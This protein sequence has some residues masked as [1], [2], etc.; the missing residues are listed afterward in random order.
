VL[1]ELFC[2]AIT[3]W[4]RKAGFIP[5]R[6]IAPKDIVSGAYTRLGIER[7]RWDKKLLAA[8]VEKRQ[9]RRTLGAEDFGEQAITRIVKML[10]IFSA[11]KPDY[12][13]WLSLNV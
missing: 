5:G 11:R 7:T 2:K 9:T 10:D 6:P 1:F 3:S 8:F 13:C 4:S 12:F